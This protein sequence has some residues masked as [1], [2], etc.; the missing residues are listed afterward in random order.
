VSLALVLMASGSGS[1]ARA[2]LEAIAQGALN[3]TV[4][5]IICNQAQ[6]GVLEIGHTYGIPT[7]C[8][9]HHGLARERHEAEIL[10]IIKKF[11]PHYLV[12]AGYMRLLSPHFIETV[13]QSLPVYATS[14]SLT[15]PHRILNIHPAL[16]PAFKGAHGYQDAFAYG[17]SVSGVTVH[18]VEAEMDSG[19]I[20]AQ[21]TFPRKAND[22]LE[23]FQSRGLT[24]EHQLYPDTLKALAENRVRFHYNQETGLSFLEVLEDVPANASI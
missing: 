11:K 15:L 13:N 21:K 22:T 17:V 6:A 7:V 9:P 3:A 19:P 10:S 12:L 16:L 5:A 20:L 4:H 23:C 14:S 24:V 8:V 2:I 1:N 18:F